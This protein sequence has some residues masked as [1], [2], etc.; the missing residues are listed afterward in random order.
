MSAP[1]G[2][3]DWVMN[4]SATGDVQV[5]LLSKALQASREQAAA[6]TNPT[7]AVMNAAAAQQ[8]LAAAVQASGLVNLYA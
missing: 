7:D 6:V 2:A 8:N 5:A 4:V 3:D 1:Q